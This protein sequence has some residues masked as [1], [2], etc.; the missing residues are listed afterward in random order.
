MANIR[1]LLVDDHK[2]LREGLR[3]LLDSYADI[4]VV[5]EA[6]DGRE[7][8]QKAARL[9]PEVVVMDIS[10]A[11]MDGIEATRR[12]R[13]FSSAPHVVV[14]TQHDEPQFVSS[15]LNAGAAGYV[16]KRMG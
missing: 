6:S 1:V 2:V 12:L 11:G 4:E 5:G 7:A 9:E 16:L 8:L 15:L 14:L 3:A 13:R 10:M